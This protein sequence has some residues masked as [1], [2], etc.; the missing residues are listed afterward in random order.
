MTMY[1]RVQIDLINF[2]FLPHSHISAHE[3]DKL[4]PETV[5]ILVSTDQQKN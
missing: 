3:S 2:S 4:K 5:K 1:T